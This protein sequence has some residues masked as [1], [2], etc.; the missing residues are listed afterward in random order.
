MWE[1]SVVAGPWKCI[2]FFLFMVFVGN[3]VML[4]L[5]LALVLSSFGGLYD[6][7]G[8]GEEG[9]EGR[10]KVFFYIKK[11]LNVSLLCLIANLLYRSFV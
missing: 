3:F 5:F 11:M 8:D 1:C 9:G 2:P 10:D 7:D 6:N 4:N